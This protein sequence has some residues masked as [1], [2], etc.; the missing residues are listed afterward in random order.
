[1][2]NTII[3]ISIII[4]KPQFQKEN[5]CMYLSPIEFGNS[6]GFIC[7]SSRP[8]VISTA[9]NDADVIYSRWTEDTLVSWRAVKS[10]AK[11]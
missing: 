4:I 9:T 3:G 1:M 7:P 8:R 5:P 2:V 10:K 11:I 6:N